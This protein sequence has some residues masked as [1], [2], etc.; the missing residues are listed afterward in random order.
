MRELLAENKVLITWWGSPLECAS[1][2]ARR[3]RDAEITSASAREARQNLSDL[4]QAW[5]EIAPFASLRVRAERLLRLHDLRASDAL[6]LSAAVSASEGAPE[7]LAFICLDQ[8]L[9][10]AAEREGFSVIG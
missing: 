2:I 8:R 5:V 3:E 1:A 10:S 9:S 7:T 4:R 6:Q